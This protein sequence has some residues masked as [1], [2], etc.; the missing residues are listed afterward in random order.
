MSRTGPG[1]DGPARPPAAAGGPGAPDG[2]EA[3][4]GRTTI[5]APAN[6]SPTR[7]A[8]A[9]ADGGTHADRRLRPLLPLVA[10]RAAGPSSTASP[11]PS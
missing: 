5:E 6:A 1:H 9:D 11:T 2:S 7:G 3:A 8:D 4:G 10:A